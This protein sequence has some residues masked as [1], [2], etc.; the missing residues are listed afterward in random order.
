MRFFSLLVALS[1]AG[2]ALAAPQQ[3]Q[4]PPCGKLRYFGV[5]EAGPEFG[6]SQFPGQP[7]KDYIWPDEQKM[8]QFIDLGM[9]MLRI[10]F[11]ME[12][13]I[14]K[15]T[16]Q[17]D[18]AYMRNLTNTINFIT[19][20]GVYAMMTPHNYGRYYQ[21]VMNDVDGFKTWWTTAA[22][23]FK[24]NPLVVFDTNNEF[25]DMDQQLVIKLNQAAIDGIRAA[26]AK[27]QIITPEGNFYTGA[28]TWIKSGGNS[29]TM[30]VLTDPAHPGD[31]SRLIYQMHQYSDSDGSGSSETCV[32]NT[33][34]ADRLVGATEWLRQNK[35]QAIIGEYA[36]GANPTCFD[37]IIGGLRYMEKN[38]DVWL[39]ALWWAA[40]PWWKNQKWYDMEPPDGIAWKEYIPKLKE[41]I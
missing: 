19:K 11:L 30:G 34:M 14:P 29:E 12:R 28:W 38:S 13:L 32:N 33:V 15:L 37:A 40:G 22:T 31:T 2:T 1:A 36:G 5:N 10:N 8:Q 21:N 4:L 9:N 18:E 41:F 26:G 39:G 7:G 27:D 20:Q 16:G 23:P 24:D 6:E 17:P 35:K 3:R 25:K